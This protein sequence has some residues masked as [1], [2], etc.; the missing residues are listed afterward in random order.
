[1]QLLKNYQKR[2]SIIPRAFKFMEVSEALPKRDKRVA[3]EEMDMRVVLHLPRS[4][5]AYQEMSLNAFLYLQNQNL[6]LFSLY[7]IDH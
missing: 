1:M 4:N 7:V 6:P 5:D 2:K 3:I